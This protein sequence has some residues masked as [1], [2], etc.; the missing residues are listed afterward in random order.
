MQP[1]EMV[2]RAAAGSLLTIGG[3]TIKLLFQIGSIA[4]LARLLLPADFGLMAMA[5]PANSFFGVFN[6]LGLTGATIQKSSIGREEISTLFWVSVAGGLLLCGIAALTAPLVARFF[7]TPQLTEVQIILGLQF[8]LSGLIA[9]YLAVMQREMRFRR[10]AL[11]DLVASV[12]GNTAGVLFAVWW[13]TYWALVAAPLCTQAALLAMLLSS[14]AWHPDR[15]RWE[16]G[17][18]ASLR[19]GGGITAFHILNFISLNID[20]I[21]VGRMWGKVSLGYYNRAYNLMAL[22]VT[23]LVNPLD[24]VMVPLLSRLR[25]DPARYAAVYRSAISKVLLIC[26]PVVTI[27]LIGSDWAVWLLLGPRWMPIVP[28]FLVL[29][30]RGL[31][32][33]LEASTVWLFISQGRSGDMMRWGIMSS[34]IV[35]SSILAGSAFGLLGVA[36]GYTAAGYILGMPL[37]CWSVGRSGPVGA[38]ALLAIMMPFAVASAFSG[39]SFMLLRM[40]WTPSPVLGLVTASLWVFGI[41]AAVM[42]LWPGARKDLVDLWRFASVFLVRSRLPDTA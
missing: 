11:L 28:V 20:N 8:P 35:V 27:L 9:Q 26:V 2:R 25:D 1:N 24:N 5:A 4:I 41:Q 18:G 19:F 40:V 6:S 16:P 3:Q 36:F 34:V 42:M 29:G 31:L 39:A 32:L 30:F 17:S 12:S 37:L 14:S 10:L 23:Q 13:P 22:P 33:P 15:P 38:G 7:N 21:I